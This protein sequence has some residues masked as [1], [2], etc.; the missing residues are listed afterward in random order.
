MRDEID[1]MLKYQKTIGV[2]Y[3]ENA[4]NYVKQARDIYN[5]KIN[6]KKINSL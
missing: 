6:K 5:K 2:I 1:I 3:Q 4:P